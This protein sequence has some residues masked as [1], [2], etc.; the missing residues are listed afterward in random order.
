M[1]NQF[2][3]LGFLFD[4]HCIRGSICNRFQV[5]RKD[6]VE[7]VFPTSAEIERS[8]KFDLLL[9]RH[10]Q[11]QTNDFKSACRHFCGLSTAAN[12]SGVARLTAEI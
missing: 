8:R 6:C 7:I 11:T 10:F 2:P 5:L 3:D 1:C 4:L 12:I 9:W